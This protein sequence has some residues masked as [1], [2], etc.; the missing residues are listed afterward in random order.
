MCG[1]ARLGS[2]PEI[3]GHFCYVH[4]P[5]GTGRPWISGH[6]CLCRSACRNRVGLTDAANVV[7]VQRSAMYVR[8]FAC[9]YC[10]CFVLTT[11]PSKDSGSGV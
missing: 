5:A 2:R 1:R 6:F 10:L 11:F 8:N 3:S 9:V 7:V 4:Q